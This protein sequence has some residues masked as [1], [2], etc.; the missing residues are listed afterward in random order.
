M[1]AWRIIFYILGL[2]PWAFIISI[3]LF[4]N[5]AERILGYTPSYG[6]PD[7]GDLDIYKAYEPKLNF[8]I[9]VWL[10]SLVLWIILIVVYFM[11]NKNKI[12]W[13]PILLSAS[14]QFIGVL[15]L[16]SGVFEWY[17]D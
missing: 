13:T 12:I 7:P 11:T 16:F 5:E 8:I 3:M 9:E 6:N 2:I 15:L 17:M 10:Y 1:T 4:Y 14:G